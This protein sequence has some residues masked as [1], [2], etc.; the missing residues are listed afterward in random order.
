MFAIVEQNI[1]FLWLQ[2]QFF[3][4]PKG[5]LKG[6]GNFL[7]FNLNYWSVPLLFK[8]LFSP[9]RRYRYSYGKRFDPK[10][11]FEVFIFNMMSRTIGAVLRIFLILV[12]ILAEIF[13]IFA[14]ALIFLAWLIL[15]VL[16]IAGLFFGLKIIF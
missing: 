11:Y 7:R 10:R 5:I 2:W 12:G 15:P 6:G 14:G 13:I 9:W 4:V 8:T 16:L 1:V 3:D